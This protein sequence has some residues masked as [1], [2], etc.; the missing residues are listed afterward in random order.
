MHEDE[1]KLSGL[2]AMHVSYFPLFD[3]CESYTF[4]IIYLAI[5]FV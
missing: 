1:F 2:F 3:I 5:L 4:L